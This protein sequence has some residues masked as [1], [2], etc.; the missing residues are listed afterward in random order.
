MTSTVARDVAH[1]AALE[2]TKDLKRVLG[3]DPFNISPY[4]EVLAGIRDK[5]DVVCR[6]FED[7][8]QAEDME[9][10]Y[11]HLFDALAL[12]N[13]ALGM[14]QVSRGLVE[15]ALGTLNSLKR[16]GGAW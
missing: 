6:R 11:L 16:N 8:D 15:A 3:A 7:C 13:E 12:I 2:I 14:K 5:L 9:E 4:R 1:I 10:H